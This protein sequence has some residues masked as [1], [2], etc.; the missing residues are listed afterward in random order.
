MD[1]LEKVSANR[2]QGLQDGIDVF[3]V[4]GIFNTLSFQDT[5]GM[6]GL[7]LPF[8]FSMLVFFVDLVVY[9]TIECWNVLLKSTLQLTVTWKIKN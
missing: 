4:A 6:T 7:F 8:C 2:K 9:M 3:L 5:L 1:W